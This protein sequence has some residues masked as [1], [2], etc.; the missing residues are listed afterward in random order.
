M[1]SRSDRSQEFP[2]H[3]CLR[4]H[5]SGVILASKIN[6]AMSGVSVLLY[7]HVCFAIGYLSSPD[8][9]TCLTCNW[10]PNSAI[11]D[12]QTKWNGTLLFLYFLGMPAA[13]SI[14]SISHPTLLYLANQ[15]SYTALPDQAAT[16]CMSSYFMSFVYAFTC[17]V[18]LCANLPF[19][20][21]HNWAS[22]AS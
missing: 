9:S 6:L 15:R 8:N 1:W 19:I 3:I 14:L 13:Y 21:I 10:L 4:Y 22:T 16:L 2:R 20:Q 18:T 12:S 17:F 11:I 5:Q 7:S